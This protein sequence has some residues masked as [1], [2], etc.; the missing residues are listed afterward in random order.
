MQRL[1]PE[2]HKSNAFLH[3][4]L[5][6]A[7]KRNLELYSM[8]M[9]ADLEIKCSFGHLINS[10]YHLITKLT[11]KIV[12]ENFVS[13]KMNFESNHYHIELESTT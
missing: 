8:E 13:L 4:L 10:E 11:G 12:V 5:P 2:V 7:E 6:P 3:F 9:F 1:R